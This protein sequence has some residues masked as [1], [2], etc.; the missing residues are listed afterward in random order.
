MIDLLRQLVRRGTRYLASSPPT[1]LASVAANEPLP[2][3]PV[4]PV[5]RSGMRVLGS[6]DAGSSR[7]ADDGGFA[8]PEGS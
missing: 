5:L 2:E 3:N 4:C 7:A 8:E 1:K 6:S